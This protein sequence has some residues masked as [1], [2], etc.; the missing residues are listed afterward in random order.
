MRLSSARHRAQR[1]KI[2]QARIACA[3]IVHDELHPK[4][5][6]EEWKRQ[7]T[8]TEVSQCRDGRD[9]SGRGHRPQWMREA[10]DAGRRLEEFAVA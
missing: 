7:R 10:L 3:K 8:R 4:T 2:A 6:H 9:V 5:L 1:Q